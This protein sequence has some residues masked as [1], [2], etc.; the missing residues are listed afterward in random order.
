MNSLSFEGPVWLASDVHLGEHNPATTEAFFRFL[1]QASAHAGALLLLGDI[2][3]A[4]IGDDSAAKP[5]PWL[6]EVLAR[7]QAVAR[8]CPLWLGR[9]NRDFLMGKALVSRIDANLL[10]E[11][12]IIEV[13]GTKAL[14]AHGD[15]FC[16]DDIGYQRFRRIVRHPNVQRFFLSLPLSW[17]VRIAQRARTKSQQTQKMLSDLAVQASPHAMVQTLRHHRIKTVIHG[18]THHPRHDNFEIDR[19]QFERWVLPD[20]ESDHLAKD[21]PPRGGWIVF[22]ENG[23]SFFSLTGQRLEM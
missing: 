10:P 4:W 12:V 17:R 5:A 21:Q 23:I 9:G 2:F 3:D 20:W 16:I 22:D 15:E 18:H 1:D 19:Y 7:L 8:R 11:Q 14:L 6:A 13:K